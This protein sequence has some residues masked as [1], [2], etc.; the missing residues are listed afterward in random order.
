MAVRAPIFEFF[1]FDEDVGPDGSAE[2]AMGSETEL[3]ARLA[4]HGHKCWHCASAVVQHIIRRHQLT[5]EWVLRRAIRCGRGIY[6]ANQGLRSAPQP[7]LFGY[8]RYLVRRIGRAAIDLALAQM[9]SDEAVKLRLRW[10]F[11]L[12]I[13]RAKESKALERMKRRSLRDGR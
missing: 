13:G 6:R 3:T 9:I 5:R 12:L 1:R 8:P 11:N 2:F 7:V 4:T 10:N